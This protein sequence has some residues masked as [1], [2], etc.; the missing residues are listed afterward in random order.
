MTTD[1][2]SAGGPLVF[3]VARLDDPD[4]VRLL[5]DYES[6]LSGQGITLDRQ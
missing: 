3:R 6:E 5:A 4:S 2:G 1:T